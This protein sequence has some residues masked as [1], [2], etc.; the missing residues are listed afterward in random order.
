VKASHQLDDI[1]AGIALSKAAPD[2]FRKADD[3]GVGVIAAMHG[4]RAKEL[5]TAFSKGHFA[6]FI[7]Q[8]SCNRYP[9][10]EIFKGKLLRDHESASGF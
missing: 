8:D 2:I 1:T 9:G 4:A 6:P 10:F 7:L 3:K 5:V